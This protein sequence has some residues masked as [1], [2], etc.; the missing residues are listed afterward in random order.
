MIL[1]DFTRAAGAPSPGYGR[2]T[3]DDL[4][5][6]AAARRPGAIALADPPNRQAFTDGQ[7]LRLSYAEADR[8]VSAI[9]GRLRRIGLPTDAVVGIQ[10]PNIVEHI[11]TLLG[12]L[13]AGLIAAPL[14]QLWRRADAVTA[15]ARV[16]ARAL[17]ACGRV[18]NFEPC[19]Q[20]TQVAAEV[21][22][23]R[24]VCGFGDKLPDG[25]VGLDDLFAAAK[26]D[27][28]PSLDRGGN[29]A[30]HLAVTTFEVGEDGPLPVARRHLELLAGG[31]S[32]FLEGRLEQDASLLSAVPPA[33][34]AGL[35]LTL[36][37]WLLAGGTLALHH[38][39]DA[40]VFARQRRNERAATLILPAA[41]AFRLAETGL[42]AR[43]GPTTVLAAWHAPERIMA[44]E[45]DWPERDAALVDVAIFGE[46]G[47]VAARRGSGGRPVPLKPSAVAGDGEN[48]VT[49]A[50]LA[51]SD[52]GTLA[53][54]GPLTPRA[55][56]PPG[57]ER[58][59]QPHLRI[60][61]DGFVD[62]GFPCRID[63]LHQTVTVTGPPS[64]IVSV[65]AYRFPLCTLLAAI[66][67]ID[68]AAAVAALPDASTGQR[69]VGTAAD[70]AAMQA[71][72]AALG[73]NPLVTAAF[74]ER[75]AQ[76]RR[77]AVA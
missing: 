39:F 43:E 55:A 51:K 65:G 70:L 53:L 27:P 7:P 48:A 17:I 77:E 60:G 18:G 54:R 42:F 10:M 11:L 56:F 35:C 26:L 58:S 38:P 24:H 5:R 32:T 6:R 25:V 74:G 4:F 28:I 76:V 62:T 37:P 22:S 16:G 61:R 2:I 66:G 12:V 44:V 30:A 67:R 15:L 14:P 63:P 31:V 13:R 71:A 29:A 73:A 75:G 52:S 45:T 47:F 64:G 34:F 1:G 46:I 20:A 21:F 8:M 69:L 9:A 49:I 33:S 57:I 3:L 72:L 50:E 68:A 59:D 19:L 36:V 40:D 23:I 41:V